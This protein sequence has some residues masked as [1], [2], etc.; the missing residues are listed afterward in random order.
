MREA[1]THVRDETGGA[2]SAATA[3]VLGLKT[4][5]IAAIASVAAFV[6]CYL[7]T[8]VFPR[9]PMMFWAD[10]SLYSTNGF[11]LLS[12][13]LPY[14][15]FFEFLTPGTDLVYALL[16]RCFGV[17]LW[18]PNLLMDI[19]AA[20]A[21]LLITLAAAKVLRGAFVFLPAVFA[22]GFGLFGGLDATHHW[23]STVLALAA[24]VVLLGGTESRRLIA[25]GALCGL[26]AS[27]TQS[28]G[29]LVTLGFVAFLIWQSR[30]RQEPAQV[31]WRR[32]LQFFG[33][34]LASFLAVNIYY[35]AKLG[36]AEWCKWIVVFPLRYYATMPGQT[37]GSPMHDFRGH[38]GAMKWLCVPFLYLVVPVIY[39]SFL[40]VMRRRSRLESDQPWNQLMLIAIT[41][42][43]MFLAVAPSLSIM[44]AST[45]S[46]P[47][48]ILLAWLLERGSGVRKWV[49][50]GL[51]ILSL[52]CAVEL[53]AAPQRK[54]WSYLD[55]PAGRTA[56]Q[57]PGRYDLY[58]WMREHTHPGQTY[59]GIAPLS[60]PLWL[61]CPSP[62]HAPGSWEYYR[63]EHIAR[64]I[65]AMEANRIPLLVLRPETEFQGTVGYEPE[66]LSSFNE[67]VALH[68]R[69]IQR[70]STGDVVW[71][72]VPDAPTPAR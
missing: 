22:V 7:R 36:L 39:V 20:I 29:A 68:Y 51:A 14:R 66:H 1:L 2:A 70:F 28:K 52:A 56:I 71:Q 18:I 19:L 27:F 69:P 37:F 43:A 3:G 57:E 15:D 45:V 33:S 30:H 67:Y 41:G 53:V 4:G 9:V 23:F 60:L 42:M 26:M 58:L 62:I 47:S 16:F 35:M 31:L 40:W 8:F 17:S 72:R 32:C 21:V 46:F 49:A 5:S 63:P 25:A 64:A 6:A 61:A 65:A 10:Q 11:R 54:H 34:V 13:Q 12:G 24:M 44:R 50:P 59:L 38:A 48:T 55:L